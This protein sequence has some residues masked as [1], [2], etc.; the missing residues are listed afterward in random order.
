[1]TKNFSFKIRAVQLDLARQMETID[2]I[3][4]FIDFIASNGYNTLA[5]YLEGRIRTA[6][7]PFPLEN[8]SYTPQQMREI[9][10]Y[11]QEREIDVIPVVSTLG[12][13]ELFLKYADLENLSELRGDSKGRFGSN[14]KHVFCPSKDA[15][16]QFLEKY[17]S[18]ITEIFPSSYFHVGCDESWDIGF[19]ELCRKRIEAGETESELYAKHLLAIHQIVSGKLGKRMIVWD[20][21]FECYP[22]AL[23]RIPRDI[24]MA[25]WQY[26]PD[27]NKTKGHFDNCAIRDSLSHYEQLGFDYLIC[28]ADYTIHNVESFTCYG[29]KH[30]PLGGWMT[31]WEKSESFMLQ[32]M[33]T[34]AYTGRL[35]ASGIN[36]NYDKLLQGVIK[37]IFGIANK[38]FIQSI[39][40]VLSR[41][42]YLE[43]RINLNAFLTENENNVNSSEICLLDIVLSVLSK[44]LDKVR[45]ESRDILKEITLSLRSEQ[46]SIEL[47]NL[48][49]H[50]FERNADI[51]KLNKKLDILSDEIEIIGQARVSMWQQ[52]RSKLL[53]CK[54]ADIY[55]NYIKNMRAIPALAREYGFLKIHFML[56]DQ[57]SAQKNRI[58]IKYAEKED[59][60]K[61]GEGVFKGRTT[62]DCFYS[63]IFLIDK[64]KNPA[65]LKIETSGFGGQGFTYFEIENNSGRFIPSAIK[66][67]LGD[68]TDAENLLSHDWQWAFAGERN[69]LK[70][71]LDSKISNKIHGFEV[72]LKKVDY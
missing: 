33:P 35:W 56:P 16:Y 40:A 36:G 21:M 38:L 9:V 55:E 61:I 17:I 72:E 43:H 29:A 5:L 71:F 19:C 11:A 58:F 22:E 28:P 65:K 10:S 27:V 3:K 52:I 13:A 18:E 64:E 62:G 14:S 15:V 37:T 32:S 7:F 2:F 69:T 54:M 4:R 30:R 23:E 49:P 53:P 67:I 59:W 50:F 8:E 12:H 25:C 70:A 1:M 68:V 39:K 66:N 57:Y 24:I 63:R 46:I 31:T 42:L 41:G 60:V 51:M 34:I 48:I 45:P 26:Q 44:Y 20:D 6:S 47:N